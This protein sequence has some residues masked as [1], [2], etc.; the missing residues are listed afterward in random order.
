MNE[1]LAELSVASEAYAPVPLHPDSAAW[2]GVYQNDWAR[3]LI[4]AVL[5]TGSVE[6]A[7][8]AIEESVNLIDAKETPNLSAV[9]IAVAS[10]AAACPRNLT[11]DPWVR[12]G[13]PNELKAVA[14][15]RADLR[16]CFV[17][18]R[19]VGLPKDKAADLLFMRTVDVEQRARAASMQLANGGFLGAAN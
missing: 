2:L 10:A 11:V 13:L 16:V 6:S 15:L 14:D 7:E 1:V 12:S 5:M 3:L 19:L 4:T 9:F 18:R 17:L 8:A